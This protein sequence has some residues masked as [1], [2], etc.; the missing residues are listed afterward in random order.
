MRFLR[1]ARWRSSHLLPYM[2][3]FLFLAKTYEAALLLR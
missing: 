2:N 3:D 1:N